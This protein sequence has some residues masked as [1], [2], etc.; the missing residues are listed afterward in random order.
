MCLS[1]DSLLQFLL[2]RACSSSR[3]EVLL[4]SWKIHKSLIHNEHLKL[5]FPSQY[6]DKWVISTNQSSEGGR[7]KGKGEGEGGRRKG[8][9]GRG[10]GEEGRGKGKRKGGIGEGERGKGDTWANL[11]SI[12]WPTIDHILVISGNTVATFTRKSSH[13]QI[14][15]YQNFLIPKSQKLCH[16]I[17]VTI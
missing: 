5:N 3:R 10:K 17:L 8:K 13:F 14:P 11:L 2:H 1:Q 7:G 15:L 12:L 9:G 4:R 16:P 6:R